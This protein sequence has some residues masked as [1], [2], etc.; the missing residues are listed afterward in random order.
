MIKIQNIEIIEF[1]G[2]RRLKLDLKGKN[3]AIC[4]RNGTGKS[5]IVDAIEFVL[6][7]NISRLSGEGTDRL[8]IKTHGPHVDFRDSPEKS[9][10]RM[11]VKIPSL[12]NRLVTIERSPNSP[13]KPNIDSAD[14][15]V[16]TVFR[17]IERHPELVLTRREI[18]RYVIATD[19][20]RSEEVQAV[21]KLE[22]LNHARATLLSISNAKA[23]DQKSAEQ[24]QDTASSGLKAAL[25]VQS[26]S[27]VNVLA[28]INTR[29]TTLG[30][31]KIDALSAVTTVK[32]G[33][34]LPTGAAGN[35][36]ISKLTAISDLKLA[37]DFLAK[38]ANHTQ[39]VTFTAAI[40]SS[41]VLSKSVQTLRLLSRESFLQSGLGFV[42]EP[43]CPLCDTP[44]EQEQLCEHIKGKLKA[45]EAVK[46]SRVKLEQK[47]KPVSDLL[48]ETIAAVE[49]VK[50]YGTLAIPRIECNSLTQYG[51]DATKAQQQLKNCLPLPLTIAVLQQ[52]PQ[53]SAAAAAEFGEIDTYLR[54]LP[55]PTDTEAARDFLIVAQE[56]L[57]TY[58]R[59]RRNLEVAKSQAELSASVSQIFAQTSDEQLTLLYRTVENQFA[60]M[61]GALNAP[62]EADFAAKLVPSL[63]KLGFDVNFYGRGFF[64]PGAY[65]SEGHQDA[66]GLCLYLALMEYVLKDDFCFAVLDDVLMSVDAGHRRLVCSLLK[67][68]FPN[69]QF[70]LT[71]H[72]PVW[73][74]HMRA[75]G[76]V[77]SGTSVQFRSWDVDTGPAVFDDVEIWDQIDRELS[78][79]RV[80]VAAGLLRNHLEYIAG[81]LCDRL[82]AK[83]EYRLD[84]RMDLGGLFPPAMEQLKSLYGKGTAAA[85]SYN[86][87]DAIKEIA[88]RSADLT[89]RLRATNSEQWQMNAAIHYNSWAN[90]TVTDFQPVVGAF[91]NLISV[92]RC[93]VCNA[94]F[95]VARDGFTNKSMACMCGKTSVNLIAKVGSL[96]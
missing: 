26:L 61:Y 93:D 92:L 30:L 20:K 32:E 49:T 79:D 43:A 87:R 95:A 23:K 84:G 39:D 56:R 59:A 5:G 11:Q 77:S 44:W 41:Q 82:H 70:I 57:E 17:E 58:R 46:E 42:D 76:L 28:S 67:T 80:P 16:L 89:D 83:V 75:D 81:E 21:L 4:G 63:G 55:D 12:S 48:A 64:P 18:I 1:R 51:K 15:E 29:R 90:L 9:V 69:T 2:V 19:G 96:A 60:A 65:H 22:S 91:R 94:L 78:L 86:Q 10:V 54:A 38:L 35:T 14:P 66:M 37:I 47:L 7:G 27:V 8:S 34:L 68:R 33:L 62:D 72:D 85:N 45:V 88:T 40:D 73:L 13:R 71:T 53:L 6:T 36:K 25:G 52:P 3:F 24:A 50:K 74:N 31:T